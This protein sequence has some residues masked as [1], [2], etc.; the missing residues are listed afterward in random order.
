[1]LGKK[2]AD[3]RDWMEVLKQQNYHPTKVVKQ[4]QGVKQDC[5]ISATF[6]IYALETFF[7]SLLSQ[8]LFQHCT[9]RMAIAYTDIIFFAHKADIDVRFEKR[10]SLCDGVEFLCS[11][12]KC[13]ILCRSKLPAE[14]VF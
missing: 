3:N 11:K 14:K 8:T 5:L 4:T 13:K 6:S 1:M 12:S 10:Q 7:E 9:G 2:L